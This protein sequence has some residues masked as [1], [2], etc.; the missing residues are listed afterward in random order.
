MSQKF[1][2]FQDDDMDYR[3]DHN[4]E[5]WE[6]KRMKKQKNKRFYN[7][8]DEDENNSEYNSLIDKEE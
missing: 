5:R 7:D 4:R 6:R 1:D 8:Y 2:K 3:K